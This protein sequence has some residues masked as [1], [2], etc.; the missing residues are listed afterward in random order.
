MQDIVTSINVYRVLAK[1]DFKRVG[2]VRDASMD[3]WICA[4]VVGGYSQ[5]SD[6]PAILY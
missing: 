6:S 1:L 2:V 5:A 4:F 3:F